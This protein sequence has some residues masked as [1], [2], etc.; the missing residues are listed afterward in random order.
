MLN[1]WGRDD[2]ANVFCITTSEGLESN[3]HTLPN[4]I[5]HRTACKMTKLDGLVENL[6]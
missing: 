1:D 2:I 6:G 5:E 4:L 3:A